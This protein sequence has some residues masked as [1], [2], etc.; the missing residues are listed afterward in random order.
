M[1]RG[2]TA[3]VFLDLTLTMLLLM[4]VTFKPSPAVSYLVATPPAT[5]ALAMVSETGLRTWSAG[6][7]REVLAP[8]TYEGMLAVSCDSP[9]RCQQQAGVPEQLQRNAAT[10][11]LLPPATRQ[12][13]REAVY[14]AC[15]ERGHCRSVVEIDGE[16]VAVRAGD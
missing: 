1:L 10:L 3:I 5:A 15:V 16:R 4:V 2:N 14:G 12:A 6:A 13:A 7:W 11:W 9:L 8:A